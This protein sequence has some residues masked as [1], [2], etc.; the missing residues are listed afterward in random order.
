MNNMALQDNEGDQEREQAYQQILFGRRNQRP[1]YM[2]Q[3]APIID[4]NAAAII[5]QQ[6]AQQQILGQQQ[7]A[8]NTVG[9]SNSDM[10][11]LGA[12]K[13]LF[14]GE[15]LPGLKRKN[16]VTEDFFNRW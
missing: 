4:V 2:Q 13:E 8:Q 6:A 12:Y 10:K 9:Q 11:A 1:S 15:A 5:Q 3:Q 16:S 14:G 7:A